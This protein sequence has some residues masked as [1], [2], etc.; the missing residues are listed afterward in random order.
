MAAKGSKTHANRFAHANVEIKQGT[1]ERAQ[2]LIIAISSYDII[3]GMSFLQDNHVS[4]NTTDSAAYFAKHDVTI[5]CATRQIR[6]LATSAVMGPMW[7]HR[8]PAA[9]ATYQEFYM[10]SWNICN[11][12]YQGF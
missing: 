6:A 3:L 7:P 12:R 4:L 5:Q 1:A 2:F 10:A 8:V 9:A 11:C